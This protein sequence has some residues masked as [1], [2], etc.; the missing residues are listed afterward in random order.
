[1]IAPASAAIPD[2]LEIAKLIE[3]LED[4]FICAE[5][6]LPAPPF[7]TLAVQSGIEE[8]PPVTAVNVHCPVA[9]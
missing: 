3:V 1:M 7:V 5:Y 2:P 6:P 8:N 9:G 4:G